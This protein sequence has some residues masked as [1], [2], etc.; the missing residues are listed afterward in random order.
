MVVECSH[1]G[2]GVLKTV[3]KKLHDVVEALPDTGNLGSNYLDPLQSLESYFVHGLAVVRHLVNAA[4]PVNRLPPEI[5]AQIFSLV[6]ESAALERIGGPRTWE[7]DLAQTRRMHALP[8]VCRYWHDVA[9]GTRSFW[10]VVW[11]A[12]KHRGE[13]IQE[14]PVHTHSPY[15]LTNDYSGPL[16]VYFADAYPRKAKELLDKYATRTRELYL[17]MGAVP[18]SSTDDVSALLDALGTVPGDALEHFAMKLSI[19][20]VPLREL[21]LF[22]GG[23]PKLRSLGIHTRNLYPANTF[24]ALTHLVVS[25][26]PW[27]LDALLD[28]LA[29]CPRLEHAHLIWAPSAIVQA[30]VGYILHYPPPP[31][32]EQRRVH[33]GHMRR[34]TFTLRVKENALATAIDAFLSR[35]A[36]PP[37]CHVYL[38]LHPQV[39]SLTAPIAARFML[40][41]LKHW[42]APAPAPAFPGIG[43]E[44]ETG[45]ENGRIPRLRLDFDID[46]ELQLAHPDGP[47]TLTLRSRQARAAAIVLEMIRS[48]APSASS[49]PHFTFAHDTTEVWIRAQLRGGGA[50]VERARGLLGA[51][52]NLERLV[53]AGNP[54]AIL[55]ALSQSSSFHADG[56]TERAAAVVCPA[57][58]TLSVFVYSR[59]DA[60][61]VR[62]TLVARSQA[63]RPVRCLVVPGPLPGAKNPVTE[64]D[65]RALG[66]LVEEVVVVDTQGWERVEVDWW[67]GR[68]REACR[69]NAALG[70]RLSCEWPTW[71][72]VGWK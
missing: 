9:L 50:D 7:L 19:E 59:G 21:S 22:S 69:G 2:T 62:A 16:S 31:P 27:T 17:I 24:P 53:V 72:D 54:A 20:N 63:G 47:G 45:S 39:G 6:T 58:E 51:L 23:T 36:L 70:R 12:P 60:E 1:M 15:P 35:L 61:A 71:E 25:D 18:A 57:L 3:T 14:E 52:P 10:P 8:T 40:A 46:A 4:R 42:P 29:R 33:L 37:A 66:A 13:V 64:A 65:V 38:A 5:M 26:A 32:S 55:Q 56:E 28:L 44:T 41:V 43:S 11:F 68:L 49:H 30:N 48:R 34:F 67:T